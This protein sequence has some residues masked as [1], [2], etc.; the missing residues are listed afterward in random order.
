[1]TDLE[2]SLELCDRCGV[3]LN[4]CPT[5]AATQSEVFSPI[6]I[7]K[8][9]QG[10]FGG[11]EVVPEMKESIY[12]CPECYLCTGICPNAIDIP[13]IVAQ[14]RIE[15]AKNGIGPLE[16]QNRIMEG[17][18]KLGNAANGDPAR[19]LDWLP[20]KFTAHESSTLFFPGC[21]CSYVVTDSAASSY[22]LLKK[23]GVD[24]MVLKDAGC[25]GVLFY[26]AGRIDLAREWFEK[27]ADRFKRLG[28]DRV[29]VTCA[30]C[31]RV[32]QHLQPQLLG[33]I[34]FKAEHIVQLLPS[35]LRE[36]GI[37][38]EPKG[39]KVTYQDPCELG[40]YEKIYDEPRE[41]L[42]LAGVTVLELPQNRENASCCGGTVRSAYRDIST[43]LASSIINEAPADPIVTSCTFCEFSLSAVAGKL[44]NPKKVE[45]IT[46]TILRALS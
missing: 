22:L 18:L 36:K 15:L 32:F 27:N 25:C 14:A 2:K 6:G 5:Y 28:I 16:K 44:K 35:L 3:C 7:V 26:H 17:I 9:A 21:L 10:I 46:S 30:G 20:E 19:S 42:R 41:A 37:E 31:Y 13:E 4:I 45:F 29:I 1:M 11:E 23:L 12:S 39:I 33:K 38:M 40:R 34:G 43:K 8:A 24:F